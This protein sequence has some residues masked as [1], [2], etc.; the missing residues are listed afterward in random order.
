MDVKTAVVGTKRCLVLGMFC[1]PLAA[2]SQAQAPGDLQVWRD[3]NE[4]VGQFKRGHIDLLQWEQAH[5]QADTPAATRGDVLAL[6]G[7]EDAVGRFWKAHPE[8]SPAL[9]R[10]P[11]ATRDA[12]A[13]GRWHA[14][15]PQW[16][17]RVEGLREVL[18]DT[19]QVRKDW[20]NA[21]AAQGA[22]LQAEEL[23]GAAESARELGERMV[24]VGNWSR[25]Q[26]APWQMAHASARMNQQRARLALVQAQGRLIKDLGLV[27]IFQTVAISPSEQALPKQALSEAQVNTRAAAARE[28]LTYAERFASRDNAFQAYEAYLG[29]YANASAAADILELHAFVVDETVLHYNGMLKSTWDVLTEAQNRM[30]AAHAAASARRDF[31]MARI[32]LEWVLLGGEPAAFIGLG[33]G[34][35]AAASAGQ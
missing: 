14:V 2:W 11:P 3:A 31:E 16:I 5:A 29:A 30:Q 22:A 25:I 32:D 10:L 23:L 18:A 19:A 8:W 4:V 13:S 1:L 26:Q 33:A 17:R 15:D 6:S 24:A 9:G 20:V 21:V 12:L 7:L 34:D 28:Q 35:G 27:G